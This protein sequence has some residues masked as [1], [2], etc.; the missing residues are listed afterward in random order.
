MRYGSLTR[1]HFKEIDMRYLMAALF[2]VVGM[3]MAVPALAQDGQKEE[4]KKEAEK[5]APAKYRAVIDGMM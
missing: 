5:T 4:Q 1:V 2:L 3:G